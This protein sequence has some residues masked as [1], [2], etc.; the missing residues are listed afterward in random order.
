MKRYILSLIASLFALASFA[1]DDEDILYIFRRDGSLDG[2]YASNITDMRYSNLDLEGVWHDQPVVQ[3]IWMADSVLR[4][5]LAE[6]DSVTFRRPDP[7]YQSD[8]LELDEQY[9]P[10]IIGQDGQDLLLESNIPDAL[11]PRVGQVVVFNKIAIQL[12]NAFAGRVKAVRQT[13]KGYVLECS[14]VKFEEIFSRFVYYAEFE[15]EGEGTEASPY[16]LKRIAPSVPT[17]LNDRRRL[18]A[19]REAEG[20]TLLRNGQKRLEVSPEDTIRLGKLEISHK[21]E[22]AKDTKLTLKGSVTPRFKFALYAGLA[23]TDGDNYFYSQFGPAISLSLGATV[24]R[25]KEVKKEEVAHELKDLVFSKNEDGTIN[26]TIVDQ[27]VPIPEFPIVSVGIK[28]GLFINTKIETKFEAS[29]SYNYEWSKSFHCA[30]GEFT[31]YDVRK[32]EGWL[33]WDI[34]GEI[35]GSFWTGLC[36]EFNIG[37]TSKV[38]TE[39]VG[40]YAGPAIDGKLNVSVKDM[41]DDFTPYNMV[42]DW[43]ART[44][45]KVKAFMGLDAPYVNWE[46]AK[47]EPKDWFFQHDLY[48]VPKFGDINYVWNGNDLTTTVE[49]SRNSF[50]CYTGILLCDET[51]KKYTMVSDRT[52]FLE[53]TIKNTGSVFPLSEYKYVPM[54]LTFKGLDPE[55]HVYSAVPFV[56]MLIERSVPFLASNHMTWV[57]CPDSH[58]PHEIDLGLPSGTKWACCNL[59]AP[60]PTSPGA[61]YPWGYT[62]EGAVAAD[63]YTWAGGVTDLG[64]ARAM[65]DS[66]ISGSKLDVARSLWGNKWNM[67]SIDQMRELFGT[68]ELAGTPWYLHLSPKILPDNY[69]LRGPN[70]RIL[71]LPESGVKQF[72]PNEDPDPV[73]DMN[74]PSVLWAGKFY[75]TDSAGDTKNAVA[76]DDKD[77]RSLHVDKHHALNVRPVT[78]GT[79]SLVELSPSSVRF[80][81]VLV[82]Q[83]ATQTL[84]LTNRINK[85]VSYD[86]ELVDIANTPFDNGGEKAFSL[87]PMHIENVEPGESYEVTVTYNTKEANNIFSSSQI[88]ITSPD[89]KGFTATAAVS[90]HKVTEDPVHVMCNPESI[91]FGKVLAGM[92]LVLD[93]TFFN[94]GPDEGTFHVG[95]E[96]DGNIFSTTNKDR[97]WKLKPGASAT[98]RVLFTPSEKGEYEDCLLIYREGVANPM[99]VRITGEGTSFSESEDFVDLGLPSG[100]LWAKCNLGATNPWM[101]GSRYAWGETTPKSKFNLSNYRFYKDGVYTKYNNRDG[102]RQLEREDDA[103]YCISPELRIP[104]TDQFN[105]LRNSEDLTKEW[106]MENGV[107]GWKVVSKVNGNYIFLPAANANSAQYVTLNLYNVEQGMT[108]DIDKSGAGFLSYERE[109]GLYIRPVH[110]PLVSKKKIEFDDLG[111]T[112]WRLDSITFDNYYDKPM[113]LDIK[114]TANGPLRVFAFSPTEGLIDVGE[115]GHIAI[116]AGEK[117]SLYV[118]AR[119][120]FDDGVSDYEGHNVTDL[121]PIEDFEGVISF[122]MDGEPFSVPV[123]GHKPECAVLRM[124]YD[125]PI[126]DFGTVTLGETS[127]MDRTGYGYVRGENIFQYIVWGYGSFSC[128]Y[129]RAPNNS[130]TNPQGLVIVWNGY[131]PWM[132]RDET[133]AYKPSSLGYHMGVAKV[134]VLNPSTLAYSYSEYIC[135]GRCVK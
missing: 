29:V 55:H 22:I 56:S 77:R 114:L 26:L 96:S 27:A 103:A 124:T 6:L 10:Y 19:K 28:G 75:T 93:V 121:D 53:E 59:K 38:V 71:V 111:P 32:D 68:C 86:L 25:G 101:M 135:V 5:P 84:T 31:T 8:V 83:T 115:K 39:K 80:G 66:D 123:I 106:T 60:D 100:T 50:P 11:L 4:I 97:R 87:E 30:N 108:F 61:Y 132:G 65:S 74:S 95:I 122:D 46:Q 116:A 47:Y 130:T 129:Y 52:H 49:V 67:P 7:E 134:G 40:I 107:Y 43:R 15:A 23:A 62:T 51:G 48:L 119:G 92:S 45:L 64:S 12:P 109:A 9:Y 85:P 3:E 128:P 41:I 44:G 21:W 125:D 33:D 13:S 70:G 112:L 69:Y 72:Y 1:A 36:L 98:L 58:H 63:A 89:I 118:M 105:E 88:N 126:M 82:G 131:A 133:Y 16:R 17:V 117:R 73:K 57:S 2:V 81:E 120:R 35:N 54:Q 102:L 37:I 127:Q 18:A 110:N 14:T 104:T 90:A 94:A 34:D 76:V 113:N 24:S 78:G 42:K 91:D 79:V 99:H 20:D